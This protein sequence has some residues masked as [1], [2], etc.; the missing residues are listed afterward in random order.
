MMMLQVFK[1][2]QIHVVTR[3]FLV[4]NVAR[5]EIVLIV[6]MSEEFSW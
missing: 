5:V 1:E 4:D 6:K 3:N 2:K